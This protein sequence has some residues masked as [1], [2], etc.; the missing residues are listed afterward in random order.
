MLLQLCHSEPGWLPHPS[1]NYI[2]R[3]HIGGSSRMML[4]LGLDMASI[5]ETTFWDQL[6][7]ARDLMAQTLFLAAFWFETARPIDKVYGLYTFLGLCFDFPLS[8]VDY[9]KTAAEVYSE[10]IWAWIRS[11]SDLSI[12]KLAGRPNNFDDVPSWVPAWHQKHSS[13]INEERPETDDFPRGLPPLVLDTP[14]SWTYME[15]TGLRVAARN[16]VERYGSIARLVFPGELQVLRARYAGKVSFAS[17]LRNVDGSFNPI[18]MAYTQLTWCRLI[19][20]ISS[21]D[22]REAVILEFFRSIYM[23]GIKMHDFHSSTTEE[24]LLGAFRTWFNFMVHLN[25]HGL[26]FPI[27]DNHVQHYTTL[28]PD[29]G[30]NKSRLKQASKFCA[31]VWLAS[32]E[33]ASTDV[34]ETRFSG[35]TE[36]R[37]SLTKLARHI[38]EV[39]DVI[40]SLRNHT[41][42]LLDNDNMLAGA[43]YWCR[44]GDEVF[45]FPGADTPFLVRREVGG[46]RYRLV[47]PVVVDRLRIIGYQKWRVEG[48]DLRNITL[49]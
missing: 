20:H 16:E 19:L 15:Q 33:K 8:D 25:D 21:S 48:A 29:E 46:Q 45:V 37:E 36:R 17:A 10:V 42:C 2:A 34:L 7:F 32:D 49:I 40:A 18:A 14:L 30:R 41:L 24:E 26:Q 3:I 28:L 27:S 13:I 6:L 38:R 11:R 23:S 5:D 43:N 47:G 4:R 22:Q 35:I 1:P 44:A 12:L 9:N 31:H 39:S